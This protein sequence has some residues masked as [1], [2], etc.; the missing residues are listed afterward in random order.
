MK[1][2]HKHIVR[3]CLSSYE[4]KT[5]SYKDV[6]VLILKMAKVT[7]VMFRGTEANDLFGDSQ[8]WKDVR[9]DLMFWSKKHH[10]L[11]GHAGFISGAK[12]V[13]N[14]LMKHIGDSQDKPLI[15]AGHSLG[16][17]LAIPT[18]ALLRG[19]GYQILEV[20]TFG[21]PRVL[22]SGHG[23]F[24]HIKVT[25]YEFG[26]D[27]VP[28]FQWWTRRKHLNRTQIGYRHRSSEYPWGC[29]WDD[30]EIINYV[31]ALGADKQDKPEDD[32]V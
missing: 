29:N 4:K 8:G 5:F 24:K 22:S 21:T 27:I 16:G 14:D 10:G 18:A 9:R 30:H 6:D 19:K 17:G 15:V 13:L 25:E 12:D 32:V 7:L 20:V 26:N 2:S 28:T 23:Q 1:L 3:R 31:R 11:K